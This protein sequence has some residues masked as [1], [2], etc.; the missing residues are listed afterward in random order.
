VPAVSRYRYV[1]RG[2]EVLIVD[3]DE[4]RVVEVIE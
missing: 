2:E 3:P 4:Q 1:T